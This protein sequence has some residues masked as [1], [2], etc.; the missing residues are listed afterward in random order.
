MSPELEAVGCLGKVLQHERLPDGRFNILL[1]GR[2]R[3]RIVREIE[4][5]TLYRQADVEILE[6]L[7]SDEPPQARRSPLV[8]LYREVARHTRTLDPDLDALLRSDPPLG[9]VTDLLAQ[10][11]GLPPVLKQALLADPA[12]D[13]RADGLIALLK[14]VAAQLQLVV[15]ADRPFPPPFSAN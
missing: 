1:L 4:A 15:E 13:R 12:V 7:A 9:V 6:D 10:A 2:K 14:Q 8:R 3:V 5:G 11:L